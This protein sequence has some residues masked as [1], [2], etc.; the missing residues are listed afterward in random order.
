MHVWQLRQRVQDSRRI[1]DGVLMDDE[2]TTTPPTPI[3]PREIKARSEALAASVAKLREDAKL[4]NKRNSN[5]ET[6]LLLVEDILKDPRHNWLG[7]LR[8]F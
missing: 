4:M 5:L 6:S 1:C 2:E 3:P 7:E 8:G